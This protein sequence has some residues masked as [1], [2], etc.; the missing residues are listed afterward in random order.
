MKCSGVDFLLRVRSE[1]PKYP[2]SSSVVKNGSEFEEVMS[3]V[4][5]SVAVVAAE[6]GLEL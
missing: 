2:S 1:G 3:R 5:S 4:K 6:G